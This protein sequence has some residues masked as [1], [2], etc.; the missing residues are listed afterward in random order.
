MKHN[1]LILFSAVIT[2]PFLVFVGYI[3]YGMAV[4]AYTVHILKQAAPDAKWFD[5]QCYEYGEG[6]VHSYE[7]HFYKFSEYNP[8]YTQG[9]ETEHNGDYDFRIHRIHAPLFPNVIIINPVARCATIEYHS[10][11]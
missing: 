3:G 10:R 1:L 7:A 11:F 6:P 5:Y 8:E 2:I 4:K 9:W